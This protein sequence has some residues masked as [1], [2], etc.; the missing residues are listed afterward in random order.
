MDKTLNSNKFNIKHPQEI[1]SSR[2]ADCQYSECG[3]SSSYT[4]SY[5]SKTATV[6]TLKENHFQNNNHVQLLSAPI[7]NNIIGFSESNQNFDLYLR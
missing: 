3:S 4:N 1:F 2:C 7:S 6:P 5:S